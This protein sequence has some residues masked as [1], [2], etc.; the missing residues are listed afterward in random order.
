MYSVVG[1]ERDGGRSPGGKRPA[2]GGGGSVAGGSGAPNGMQANKG[3]T[4]D[5]GGQRTTSPPYCSESIAEEHSSVPSK[6]DYVSG[7]F[8]SSIEGYKGQ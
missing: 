5:D 6:S 3:P 7:H 2:V 4:N 8:H 1:N